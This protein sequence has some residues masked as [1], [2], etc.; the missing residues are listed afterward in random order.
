MVEP[1]RTM[2]TGVLR[3]TGGGKDIVLAMAVRG[4]GSGLQSL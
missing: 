3:E 4:G 1:A 2:G